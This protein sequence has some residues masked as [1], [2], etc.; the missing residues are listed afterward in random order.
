MRFLVVHPAPAFSVADVYAGWVEALQELGQQVATFN[1]DDRLALYDAALVE[2][3]R[4]P[5]TNELRLRKALTSTQAVRLAAQGLLSE[6]YKVWPDVILVISGFF[7]DGPMLDLLRSRRHRVVLVHTEE[8]YEHARQLNLSRHADLTVLND[9]TNLERYQAEGLQAMYLPHAYRPSVHTPGPAEP[10]LECDLCFVGTGYPSRVRFL[11]Q[12]DLAELDV[13]LAGNW[14]H[15]ADT[16]PLRGFVAHDPAECLDNTQAVRIYRSARLGLNLYRRE[17]DPGQ[18]VGFAMG[19]REVEL[20]AT[21][22][23]FLRDPRP[24]GD[25]ILPM[26][27]TFTTP[28][29]ASEMTRWWLAHPTQRQAAAAAARVAVADRTFTANAAALL[30]LLDP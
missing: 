11:E 14:E 17:A 7:I 1:L 5:I 9:P 2:V 15:L 30:R 18:E 21:G 6:T 29:E 19:P 16:S 8:P 28:S 24:E 25:Q 10:D 26:L 20:A 27:P 23:F 3:G 4:D 13:L 22:C 12:M